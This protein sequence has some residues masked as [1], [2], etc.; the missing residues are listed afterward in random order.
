[1]FPYKSGV[2]VIYM[3]MCSFSHLKYVSFD[4][5]LGGYAPVHVHK[6]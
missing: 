6:I 2:P 1:M 4:Q 3:Y 5:V